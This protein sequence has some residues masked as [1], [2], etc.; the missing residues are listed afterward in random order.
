MPRMSS[1]RLPVILVFLV[2]CIAGGISAQLAAPLVHAQAQPAS[3]P[4]PAP[5]VRWEHYCQA[6]T[7]EG[8]KVAGERG[9]ELVGVYS[10]IMSSSEN[11]SLITGR[12]S[13]QTSF[14]ASTTACYKRPLAAAT[15]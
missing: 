3:A 10:T 15:R 14:S 13:E 1:R 4:A 2:G 9:W 12:S 11:G 8:A 6:Y 5:L 7:P